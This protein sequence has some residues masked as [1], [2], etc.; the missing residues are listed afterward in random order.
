VEP[1]PE[2]LTLAQV[3]G[4]LNLDSKTLRRQF[5]RGFPEPVTIGRTQYFYPKD[6]EAYLYLSSRGAFRLLAR[7]S[8]EEDEEDE[9]EAKP[10]T[11]RAA[12]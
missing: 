12:Q 6:I 7:L 9:D 5:G 2:L 4:R 3:A 8:D 11:S 10:R 1:A